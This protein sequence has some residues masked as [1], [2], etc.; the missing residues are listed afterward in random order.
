MI[1]RIYIDESGD[2]GFSE[3]SSKYFV[4]T[5]FRISDLQNEKLKKIVKNMRRNKFKKK[6]KKV[7][8]I[9]ASSSSKEIITYVLTQ[10]NDFQA[11]IFAVTLN[12]KNVNKGLEKDEIYKIVCGNI[13]KIIPIEDE[14]HIT[15][16]KFIKAGKILE[17]DNC[18]RKNLQLLKNTRP[19][20]I[21]HEQS[22]SCEGLQFA[23][24]VAYAFFSEIRTQ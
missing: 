7:N 15:I 2:L 1:K 23:D 16:D 9:K 11:E 22:N 13:A 8:E 5:A 6:L 10:L 12:K 18:F 14:S 20:K 19:V 21:F 3:R 24:V 4:V 17:F